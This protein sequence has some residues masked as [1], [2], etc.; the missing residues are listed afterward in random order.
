MRSDLALS[1]LKQSSAA[2][3]AHAAQLFAETTAH[4]FDLSAYMPVADV[5]APL[6]CG[7]T[8]MEMD[9]STGGIA[10]LTMGTTNVC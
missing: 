3:H 4:P 1:A 9:L 10:S 8:R 5:A 2:M 7:S 6:L